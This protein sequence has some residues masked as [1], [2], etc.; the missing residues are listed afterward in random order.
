ML[1]NYKNINLGW[2]IRKRQLTAEEREDHGSNLV[3]LSH[4][5]NYYLTIIFFFLVRSSN[6]SCI[7]NFSSI[8]N[9]LKYICI[10]LMKNLN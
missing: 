1:I 4:F 3:E 5:S 8:R 6:V 10:L 9:V 7:I 2:V